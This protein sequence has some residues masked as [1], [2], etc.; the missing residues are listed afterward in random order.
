MADPVS[1]NI[2]TIQKDSMVS[3]RMD[4]VLV[5]LVSRLEVVKGLCVMAGQV[6]NACAIGL[7][8]PKKHSTNNEF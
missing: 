8:S 2:L 4:F 7:L 5:R 6:A 1:I 3:R